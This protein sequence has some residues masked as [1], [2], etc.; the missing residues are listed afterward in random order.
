MIHEVWLNAYMCQS[1]LCSQTVSNKQQV[2]ISV[3]RIR[4][5]DLVHFFKMERNLVACTDIDGLMQTLYIN[6][7]PLHWRLFIDS[8]I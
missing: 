2:R 5:K 8:S 7:N 3:Y 1:A 4:H 6:R